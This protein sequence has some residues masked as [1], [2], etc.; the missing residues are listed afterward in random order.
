MILFQSQKRAKKA[1]V[2]LYMQMMTLKM[3]K[4]FMF[5]SVVYIPMRR[6]E[7]QATEYRTAY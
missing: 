6:S 3:Q 4:Q 7:K 1:K 5:T 2:V